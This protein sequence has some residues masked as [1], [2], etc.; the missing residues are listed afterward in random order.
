MIE[1]MNGLLLMRRKN[2][3]SEL[4]VLMSRPVQAIGVVNK[5]S[6][7]A[8]GSATAA[9]MNAARRQYF[10]VLSLNQAFACRATTK[11][12]AG[13]ASSDRLVFDVSTNGAW[14]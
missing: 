9:E 8:T 14:M 2:A 3:A 7:Q 10:S 1:P 12:P 5:P 11:Y 6:C 13:P 4:P